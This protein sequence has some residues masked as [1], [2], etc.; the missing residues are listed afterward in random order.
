[1]RRYQLLYILFAVLVLVACRGGQSSD[2][3]PS[4]DQPVELSFVVQDFVGAVPSLTGDVS[5]RTQSFLSLRATETG[6]AKEQEIKNLYL[7]MFDSNG[8]NPFRYYIEV[9][10]STFNGGTYDG[11]AKK[12]TL[13]KTQLEAGMRK[14]Y[15]VANIDDTI[16]STLETVT[17]ENEFLEKYKE[18]SQPWGEQIKAPLL[19][20]GHKQHNFA[21]NPAAFRLNHIDL[22]R[23][24]AKIELNIELSAPYQVKQEKQSEYR[25]RFVGFDKRTYF[26]KPTTDKPATVVNSSDEL[27]Q[28]GNNWNIWDNTLSGNADT[29][30][31]F[32]TDNTANGKVTKLK[33]ITYINEQDAKGAKV[34][35]SLPRMDEGPLPPPEF[36][37]ELY[38]FTL[39]DKIERNKWYKLELAI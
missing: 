6:S 33:L 26:I 15:L 3:L 22:V 1:M 5:Q 10:N 16:K 19:M 17:T 11:S 7:L 28:A 23:A 4:G 29:G 25:Y 39:P 9:S 14:V 2:H 34:E 30:S 20:C 27:W 12:I 8:A 38:P 37:P 24:V 35:I 32:T 18:T 31:S 36:G 21:E 13:A